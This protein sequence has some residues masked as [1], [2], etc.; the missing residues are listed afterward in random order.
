MEIFGEVI[1]LNLIYHELRIV[2]NIQE[3]YSQLCCDS[4]SDEESLV[5]YFIVSSF[6]SNTYGV[7]HLLS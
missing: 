2:V 3:L 6:E 4:Q 1:S 5:L 7:F